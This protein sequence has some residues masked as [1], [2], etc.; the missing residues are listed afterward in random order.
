M[1]GDEKH[2][3]I[4]SCIYCGG[5]G[6]AGCGMC[7]GTGEGQ[8]GDPGTSQCASC[9]GKETIECAKCK[10]TGTDLVEGTYRDLARRAREEFTEG[11]ETGEDSRRLLALLEK[12]LVEKIREEK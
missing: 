8:H 3:I 11:D 12:F 6:L 10:G 4:I 7:G 5:D 9:K 1:K 2:N